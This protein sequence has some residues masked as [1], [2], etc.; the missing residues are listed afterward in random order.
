MDIAE[1]D[2]V[3]ELVRGLPQGAVMLDDDVLAAYSV[4]RA[5]FC[6]VGK[7]LALVHARTTAQVQHVLQVASRFGVPVVPQGARSGLS[8]AANAVDGCILLSLEKMK[9]I[10]E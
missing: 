6:P 3:Q 1:E 9:D 8:G 5:M 10:L 2:V 4:D 7:A